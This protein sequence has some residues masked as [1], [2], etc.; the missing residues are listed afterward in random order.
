MLSRTPGQWRELQFDRA[1]ARESNLGES[2]N[3]AIAAML[4]AD[5]KLFYAIHLQHFQRVQI[6]VVHG[7]G[8][9][10]NGVANRTNYRTR[11]RNP[12]VEM[13]LSIN[14]LTDQ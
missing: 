9:I 14:D 12:D 6:D 4:M 7:G 11:C 5:I 10:P 8:L 13:C 2:A 3:K 1:S